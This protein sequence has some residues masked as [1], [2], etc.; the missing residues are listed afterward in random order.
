M[1]VSIMK[2]RIRSSMCR[3]KHNILSIFKKKINSTFNEWYSIKFIGITFKQKVTFKITCTT[4]KNILPSLFFAKYFLFSLHISISFR[5][6]DVVNS[7]LST[8]PFA[9]TLRI[10]QMSESK[11]FQAFLSA[12]AGHLILL[13]TVFDVFGETWASAWR[14]WALWWASRPCAS[15]ISLGE[16]P[17][18]CLW[19]VSTWHFV[20][21]WWIFKPRIFLHIFP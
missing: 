19:P 17:V 4:S 16:V 10:S 12:A 13:P 8:A 7:C 20:R 2:L 14:D 18:R 3:S 11:S 5:C 15:C 6:L 21:A 1:M 9:D